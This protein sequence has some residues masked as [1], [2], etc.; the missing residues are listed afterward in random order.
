MGGLELLFSSLPSDKPATLSTF[1]DLQLLQPSDTH[2]L[3]ARKRHSCAFDS[4]HTHVELSRNLA[5]SLSHS[6]SANR[7]RKTSRCS[8]SGAGD[9]WSLRETLSIPCVGAIY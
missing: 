9:R 8:G 3:L 2:C 7:A 5:H 6:S 4:R 1:H